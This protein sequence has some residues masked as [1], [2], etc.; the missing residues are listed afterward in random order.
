VPKDGGWSPRM[1]VHHLA[2]S[3]SNSYPR[4]RKLLAEDDPVVQGYDQAYARRLHYDRPVETSLAVF[5]AVR[6]S[7]AEL[8]ERLEGQD[9]GRAG[10]HTESGPYTM[11]DWLEIYAAYAFDHAEQIR[12]VRGADL[13]R[14]LRASAATSSGRYELR[15]LRAPAATSFSRYFFFAALR[16]APSSAARCFSARFFFRSRSCAQRTRA[17]SPRPIGAS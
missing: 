6:A 9:R 11:D 14:P 13:L 16:S 12:R 2:D 7:T 4:V 15:P 1:V 3:E 17:R 10:T 5:R 8:L